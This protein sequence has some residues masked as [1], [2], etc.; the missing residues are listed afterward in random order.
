[1]VFEVI[2]VQNIAPENLETP[3]ILVGVAVTAAAAAAAAVKVFSP[4]LLPQDVGWN[5]GEGGD[6]H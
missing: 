3:F 2:F 1:M 4:V 6:R 5:R